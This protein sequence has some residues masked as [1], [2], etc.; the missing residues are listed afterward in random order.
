MNA[1][2]EMIFAAVRFAVWAAGEGIGPADA[3]PQA[4]EDFLYIFSRRTGHED[5]DGLDQIIR[6]YLWSIK[7]GA[8]SWPAHSPQA[9]TGAPS[10]D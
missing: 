7:V 8:G 1:Y 5:W 9:T 4:P 10:N 3:E 6:Q 2:E